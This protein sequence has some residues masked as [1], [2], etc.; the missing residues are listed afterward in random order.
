M[1]TISEIIVHCTATR[2]GRAVDVDDVRRWH[3]QR[4]F[5]DIA[6][7]FLILLDGTVQK[8]RPIET[9]GAHCQGHNTHSIGVCYVGGLDSDGC[10]ADTRTPEQKRALV[11]LLSSLKRQFPDAEIHSHRDFAAKACPCFDAT[12][13]YKSKGSESPEGLS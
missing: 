9:A 2:S 5:F 13:E 12:K 6:Y 4:G 3:L 7:H 10:P 11:K 1:R 8:G